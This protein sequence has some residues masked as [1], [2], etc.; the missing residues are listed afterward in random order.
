MGDP[1]CP[2]GMLGPSSHPAASTAGAA[3]LLQDGFTHST[4]VRG[5]CTT[6]GLL[7]QHNEQRERRGSKRSPAREP[8]RLQ[9]ELFQNS[10]VLQS[11]GPAGFLWKRWSAFET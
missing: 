11:S 4:Q 7:L 1:S 6:Q 8:V 10:D 3:E 5:C 9:T 2:D